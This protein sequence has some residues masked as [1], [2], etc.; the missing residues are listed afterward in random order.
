MEKQYS[1]SVVIPTYNRGEVLLDTINLLLNQID[2]AEEVLVV[3]QTSYQKGDPISA[4]LEKLSKNNLIIWVELD[5]ASIPAAMNKGLLLAKSDFILFLDDDVSF[6]DQF[7]AAHRKAIALSKGSAHVGQIL[8]PGETPTKRLDSYQPGSGLKNDLGF[9]FKSDTNAL[10]H[11]CM[12]GNLLVTRKIA[13]FCGGF[14][15]QFSGAAYRFETEFCRRMIAINDVPFHFI[16]SATLNHLQVSVGGTR[17]HASSFLTSSLPV[18]SQGDYYFAMR[19]G[20]TK[21]ETL[22]YIFMR[23]LSSIYA[24]FYLRKPWWIPVRI[25]AEIRGIMVALSKC[26]QGPKIIR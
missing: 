21:L 23:F 5:E 6:D 16:P 14:D 13:I 4:Q 7:I 11:N 19:C 10:I 17:E 20:N 26:K 3:D 25:L 22:N 24:R 2:K 9:P 15:E 8:Q 12:A 1:L 18:H